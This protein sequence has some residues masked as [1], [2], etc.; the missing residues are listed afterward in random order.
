MVF[1]SFLPETYL[2]FVSIPKQHMGKGKQTKPIWPATSVQEWW[3]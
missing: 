2:L 1:Y 3:C